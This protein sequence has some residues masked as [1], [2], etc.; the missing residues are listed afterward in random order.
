M[1]R[2]TI[3]LAAYFVSSILFILGVKS[4][5]HPDTARRGMQSAYGKPRS[6]RKARHKSPG[7]R[8]PQP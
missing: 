2:D 8:L 7:R 5:T 6:V 4:L 1:G 3:V